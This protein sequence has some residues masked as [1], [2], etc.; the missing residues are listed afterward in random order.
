V[1]ARA[2]RRL[3]CWPFGLTASVLLAA[4]GGHSYL[5][6]VRVSILND[7]PYA[8]VVY[9]CKD[10]ACTAHRGNGTTLNPGQTMKALTDDQAT[11]NPYKVVSPWIASNLD[12]GAEGCLRLIFADRPEKEPTTV[13]V[14][15]AVGCR[16]NDG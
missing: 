4:C 15:R 9:Q 14:S 16:E 1:R 10:N 3:E 7:T 5:A 11:A 8:V 6:G 12:V 2:R 13:R